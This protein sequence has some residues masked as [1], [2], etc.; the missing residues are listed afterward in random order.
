MRGAERESEPAK[1]HHN[2]HGVDLS[3]FVYG[4][5]LHSL[6]SLANKSKGDSACVNTV[7]GKQSF[8]H[9]VAVPA[10]VSCLWRH[11]G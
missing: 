3:I 6:E 9:S 10:V 11:E 8:A 4:L 2:L 5:G 1:M 7:I